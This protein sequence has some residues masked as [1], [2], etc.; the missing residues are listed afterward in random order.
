MPDEL[1]TQVRQVVDALPASFPIVEAVDYE[2]FIDSTG[3]PALQFLVTLRDR[4]DQDFYDLDE[5]QP[6]SDHLIE[7]LREA[8]VSEIPFVSF[9]LAT[10]RQAIA[11]GTYYG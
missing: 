8:H 3:K 11:A 4:P 7:R 9:V 10:E 6:I 1:A 2:P 5:V